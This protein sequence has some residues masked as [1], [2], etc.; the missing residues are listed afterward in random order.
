MKHVQYPV[1]AQKT[2][3]V[4][5]NDGDISTRRRSLRKKNSFP[6]EDGKAQGS[7]DLEKEVARIHKW[8]A[9]R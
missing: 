2:K 1:E 5:V 4:V 3:K 9:V 8:R 6:P 7:H